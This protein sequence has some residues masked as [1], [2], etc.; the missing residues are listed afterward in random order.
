MS[1]QQHRRAFLRNA[2]FVAATAAGV[3]GGPLPRQ[4][5]AIEPIPRTGKAKFKFSLAAYS[6]RDLLSGKQPKMTLEEFITACA[7]MGLDGTE[8]TSYYFP[9]TLTPDYL[10]KVKLLAFRLG[11]DVTATSVGNDFC[12]TDGEKLK[13]QIRL[14]KQWI[15]NAEILGAPAIRIFSGSRKGTQ[16]L[17]DAYRMAIAAIEE[18]CDYA[19]KHGVSL[20][21]ENHGGLTAQVDGILRLIQGVKS[22]WF[23]VN[24]DAGN[25]GGADPYGDLAK[26]APYAINTHIKVS[27]SIAGKRT[28]ADYRRLAKILTDAGYRGY[29]S[30]EYEEREDP[31]VACPRETA[32]IREAFLAT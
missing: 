32:R 25:F 6:Y 23:G 19:G 13:G 7:A 11:L 24:L 21:L 26:I 27:L 12:Q 16:T 28:Q 2:A 3:S 10:R 8:L 17:D 15:D 9:R 31:L 5:H 4:S 1:N 30:L 14:T 18:C 20:A 29:I 22:P